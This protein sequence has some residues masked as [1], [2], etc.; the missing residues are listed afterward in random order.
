M[1]L[2]HESFETSLIFRLPE[3]RPGRSEANGEMQMKLRPFDPDTDFDRIHSWISDERSHAMWCAGRFQYPLE[4]SDFTAVLSDMAR[5]T[6]DTPLVAAPDGGIAAGFFCYSLN[7]K[8]QEGKLKF[9]IVD[10]A[11][12]GKGVAGEMLRLGVS[13]AFE[14]PDAERVSLIVFTSNPRARR[15]YEKAGFS[16]VEKDLQ[17]FVWKDE[18]WDRCSMV[19][20]R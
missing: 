8:L 9:V 11:Y 1:G 7:R 14:D 10:P 13:R 12:R 3:I 20:S 6:G 18:S 5:N 19:I 2:K 15:C 4:K 17:P 16:A